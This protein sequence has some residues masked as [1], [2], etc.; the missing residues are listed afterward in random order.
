MADDDDERL[1]S[2]LDKLKA[3]LSKAREAQGPAPVPRDRVSEAARGDSGVSLGMRAGSEFI[4]AIIVGSGVGWALDRLLG[5]NPAFLIVF[6]MLG[7]AAGVWGVVRLTSPK[8]GGSARD[9]RLSHPD[10]ADKGFSRS[11]P[12]A[13][14]DASPG[15]GASRGAKE[16]SGGADDDED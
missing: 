13:E 9:S 12:A 14:P 6:F 1:R 7:V 8:G 3:S 15:R 5:T 2:G 10:A 16:A 4:S 11:A